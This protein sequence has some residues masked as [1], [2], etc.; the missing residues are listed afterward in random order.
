MKLGLL[1]AGW[2]CGVFTGL[3]TDAAF[4]PVALLLMAAL[5]GS[6]L[7]LFCR[8]SLWPMLL[9][10]ALL[11]A[12]LRVGVAENP[13]LLFP[14]AD[15]QTVT[16]QGRITNDPESAGRHIKLLVSVDSL[17]LGSGLTSFHANILTYAEPPASL[18]SLR[19]APYFQYGDTVT[20]K[21]LVQRPK[22][23]AEFDYPSY[24][25][26][27][28]IAGIVFARETEVANP[29]G[30]GNGGWR[31]NIYRLRRNL[32]AKLEDALPMPQA[33]VAQA[34]L[35]GQ[36]GQLPDELVED[37]RS[38]GTSHL[39][40]IS[41]MH[42]G[43][44]MLISIAVA[45]GILGRQRMAYIVF[46][47][48]VIWAYALISG[49]PPSVV[50]AAIMGTVF[51]A[52][53]GLGRSRSILP[54]LALT[55]AVMTAI[56]PH[57]IQQVSFQLSF[58]AMAGIALAL[59]R[60]DKI[61]TAVT[62][63]TAKAGAGYWRSPWLAFVLNWAAAA[64]LVSLAA[65]LATW[66]LVAFNFDR[67][68][69]LGIF[70]TAIS[71]PALPFILLSSMATALAGLAHPVLGQVFGWIAWVPISYL[72]ELVS[73]APP[74]TI[75]GAWV[76]Q[77]L[78]W[79]WYL[80][81]G[82]MVLLVRAT[83]HRFP[84]E[85]ILGRVF[86]PGAPATVVPSRVSGATLGLFAL[87]VL[88][89]TACIFVWAQVFA[90]PDGKLHVY[91]FDVGQGDSSL[92]VTPS[93]KQ[94]LI[95][96]GPGT[97]SATS[98]LSGPLPRGDRS[99]DMIVLTH[100]DADHSRG[101]LKVM[102]RYRVASAVVG[103][104]DPDSAMY[105]HWQAELEKAKVLR[106]PVRAGYRII[107]EPGVILEVLNPPSRPIGGSAADQNNN[108]VV[109]RLVHGNVSFLLA[110]DIEAAA[111][112]RL[113]HGP[114]KLDSSVLKVAH[115]G[116]RT[117]STPAFLQRVDPSAVVVSV[118]SANR[119]G[120]PN[121]EVLNRLAD[122]LGSGVIYRTDRNGTVEFISDGELLWVRTER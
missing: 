59:P 16:L 112:N 58:T 47:I 100:L 90:G 1:A 37:F 60:L 117:S 12:L 71:L 62:T 65:S 69:L 84:Q 115:H 63:M 81:L 14:A 28:G 70:V 44:L 64:L 45:A 34:L 17:D 39:L 118:G 25:A 41:G 5:A 33:A 23:L 30:A 61:S 121:P 38:T 87:A 2:L 27:Q 66:P 6:A 92:I 113:A 101:L 99:L 102:D 7:L 9:A 95:D 75:S 114:Q 3:Q 106:I 88:L 35:L 97:D 83:A 56:S 21:G 36:R 94:I 29:Q 93:G 48:A 86:R 110:A 43:S 53:L 42:V 80:G 18:I 50:R 78:V 103:F 96:G 13:N 54:A 57:V 26:K 51:L 85:S 49:L 76:S 107:L 67:V 24:L 52:A 105:P 55:A 19:E 11:L 4:L 20:V 91:F 122:I 98:A 82:T 32:S 116:S 31:G 77:E 15:G 73:R 109:L 22:A 46:P 10:V 68:P 108:A 120:H 119:F 74:I 104:E 79:G 111:E 72:V 89:L 8:S 40:A